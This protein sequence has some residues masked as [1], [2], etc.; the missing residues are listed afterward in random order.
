LPNP[1]NRG[2]G[3]VDQQLIREQ[4]QSNGVVTGV[5]IAVSCMLLLWWITSRLSGS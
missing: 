2:D 5:K 1:N 4:L 3:Q